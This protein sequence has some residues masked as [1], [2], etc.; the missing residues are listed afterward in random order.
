MKKQQGFTL[1]ELMIVIAIIGIIGA[2]A[3]P[4]FAEYL[5]RAEGVSAGTSAKSIMT[6]ITG[7]IQLGIDCAGTELSIENDPNGP[8]AAA[9]AQ[10][11]A[12]NIVFS[13]DTCTVTAA[14]TAQGVLNRAGG[15]TNVAATAV[16]QPL[17]M[18]VKNGTHSSVNIYIRICSKEQ[19]LISPFITP[20]HT[21]LA[22]YQHY[23]NPQ[24]DNAIYTPEHRAPL[25]RSHQHPLPLAPLLDRSH[26]S[27]YYL[28]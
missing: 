4:Q 18:N 3:I 10:D 26:H 22:K 5:E 14:Y 27:H 2:I 15:A 17:L 8:A 21:L 16:Q 23:S 24:P 7:C 6:K 12:I 1:I 20:H 19:I 28:Q 9:L 13:N 25:S 11:T